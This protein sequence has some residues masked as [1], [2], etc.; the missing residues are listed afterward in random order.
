VLG[1]VKDAVLVPVS[2]LRPH[3]RDKD[4]FFVRVLEN[5]TVKP[6]RVTIGLQDRNQAEVKSGL[7]PGEQ[8]VVGA[9]QRGA[10]QK[11]KGFSLP[12]FGR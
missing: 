2:A 5:G 6:K 9:V 11:Q 3:P 8:V 7:K 4:A 12:K 1:S 10:D